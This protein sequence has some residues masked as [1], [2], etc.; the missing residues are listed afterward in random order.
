MKAALQCMVFC[1]ACA[2]VSPGFADCTSVTLHYNDRF[3]YLWKTADGVEGL[4]ATPAAV[5]FTRAGIP[6]EWQNTPTKRQMKILSDNEDCDCAVGWF[7]NPEREKFARY[8]L[9]IYQDKQQIAL[10]RADNE[11][12]QNG[13]TVDAVLANVELK[14][15]VK[16]GYSYGAFLD[17]K[18]ALHKPAID[19]TASENINMLKKIHEKRA[20]YF[21]IA[22][23]EADSLIEIST[24]PKQDFKYISFADMPKGEERYIL[25]SKRVGIEIIQ[26]LNTAITKHVA[27]KKQ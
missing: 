9:P 1:I 14:L 22:P 23:E 8:T 26:K 15:A 24:L 16:D 4:T 5:S 13:M 6:F 11:L 20:D 7:K 2:S 27:I 10:T 21:F 18:I 17:E 25:C 12:I 19:T 3:P